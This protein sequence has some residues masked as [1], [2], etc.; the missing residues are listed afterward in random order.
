[1]FCKK[2]GK[3][4][5]DGAAFCPY[6]GA[7]LNAPVG[8]NASGYSGAASQGGGTK[9]LYT[10]T[11][12]IWAYKNRIISAIVL[13]ILGIIMIAGGSMEADLLVYG[14]AFGVV[15]FVVAILLVTFAIIEARKFKILFYDGRVIV[16]SGVFNTKE[17]QSVMTPVV[18]VKIEQSIW[19]KM[20]KYGDI[21]IDKMGKGWDISTRYIKDPYKLKQFLESL[22]DTT[23]YSRMNMLMTN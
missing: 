14:I 22:I 19:G 11:H 5:N 3:A 1:M 18:G 10:A 6:C 7:A 21:V 9:L 12:S 17:T 2:C 8:P 16:K 20:F 15:L 13:I 23:D 4:V